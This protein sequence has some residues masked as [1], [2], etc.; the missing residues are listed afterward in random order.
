MLG[1]LITPL[2]IALFGCGCFSLGAVLACWLIQR[3]IH[4]EFRGRLAALCTRVEQLSKEIQDWRSSRVQSVL[5]SVQTAPTGLEEQVNKVRMEPSTVALHDPKAIPRTL[6]PEAWTS[7][8]PIVPVLTDARRAEIARLA[9]QSVTQTKAYDQIASAATARPQDSTKDISRPSLFTENV[10]ETKLTTDS[11]TA[12]QPPSERSGEVAE[13]DR[14]VVPMIREMIRQFLKQ[15]GEF[16]TFGQLA[17]RIS[18]SDK[19]LLHV[20]AENRP[21]LFVVTRD[22]RSIKL[23]SEAVHR[24]LQNGIDAVTVPPIHLPAPTS[25]KEERIRCGHFSQEELLTDLQRCSLPAEALTRNC[26]WSEICRLR[27]LS[28]PPINGESWR[29]ICVTRGYLL[30]R[31]NPRGF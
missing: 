29:E 10:I 25:P 30:A 23:H 26:C 9:R 2:Q 5:S 21:D 13:W 19:D 15:P 3:S 4:S 12:S 24:I 16:L 18:G 14:L 27:A 8:P 22:E 17:F 31:Q 1:I 28:Q 6:A 7:S 11:S 20:V